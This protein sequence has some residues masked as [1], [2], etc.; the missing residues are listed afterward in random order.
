ML[1]INIQ[2]IEFVLRK[3]LSLC[4]AKNT[5]SQKKD[6]D[7]EEQFFCL[8]HIFSLSS[9]SRKFLNFP[10]HLRGIGCASRIHVKTSYSFSCYAYSSQ[11]SSVRLPLNVHHIVSISTLSCYNCSSTRTELG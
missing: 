8:N 7:Y 6:C 11:K 9:S 5:I 4:P 3:A 2:S 1:A 10:E